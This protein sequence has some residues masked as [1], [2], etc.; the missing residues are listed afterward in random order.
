MLFNMPDIKD[1]IIKNM[2]GEELKD[3]YLIY[4]GLEK[5]PY[6]ISSISKNGQR[7]VSLPLLYLTKPTD[8]T[9]AYYKNVE[10]KEILVYENLWKNDLR[11]LV[12]TISMD[13]N[14]LKVETTIE[15]EC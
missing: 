11:T 6:K 1:L 5:R 15:N 2:T 7:T 8:L 13:G 3:L 14:E 12:L 10:K 4:E 9:L